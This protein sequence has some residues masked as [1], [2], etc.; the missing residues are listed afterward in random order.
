M[1]QLEFD[2]LSSTSSTDLWINDIDKFTEAYKKSVIQY[3]KDHS[4]QILDKKKL[5]KPRKKKT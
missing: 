1:K 3:N 2:K 4:G 5:K